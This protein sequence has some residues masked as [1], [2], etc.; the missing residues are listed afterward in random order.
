MNLFL[1]VY[2]TSGV[3]HM[4]NIDI[5]RLFGFK[6]QPKSICKLY[7]ILYAIFKEYSLRETI[8]IYLCNILLYSLFAV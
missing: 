4:F 3:E 2:E 6:Q 5:K 7:K 1:C 8:N